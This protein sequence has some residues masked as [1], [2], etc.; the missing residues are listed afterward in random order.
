[1]DIKVNG[2][3]KHIADTLSLAEL[4]RCYCKNPQH[5]I[6][7]VNESIIKRPEWDT[8]TIADGDRVELVTFVGGG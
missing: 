5:V 3:P 1:M 4:V 6:A 2:A 8:T 7:E